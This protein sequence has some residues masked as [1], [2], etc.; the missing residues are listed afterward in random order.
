MLPS[1]P[2]SLIYHEKK[3]QLCSAYKPLK[4]QNYQTKHH[5]TILPPP[6]YVAELVGRTH[7][8]CQRTW[9]PAWSSE[10]P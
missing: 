6:L 3:I 9:D 2:E 1:Q 8:V 10:G 4:T 5:K 7:S